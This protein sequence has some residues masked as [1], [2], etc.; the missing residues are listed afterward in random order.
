MTH[1]FTRVICTQNYLTI[2]KTLPCNFTLT[3]TYFTSAYLLSNITDKSKVD[4]PIT[5]VLITIKRSMMT[6]WHVTGLYNDV[7][8]ICFHVT[9]TRLSLAHFFMILMMYSTCGFPVF[10]R[11]ASISLSVSLN[12][13]VN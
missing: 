4:C 1:N 3:E 5:T 12:K 2:L 13:K 6:S 7:M 9:D 11:M 10:L 8:T